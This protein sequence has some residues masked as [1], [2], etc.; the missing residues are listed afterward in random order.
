MSTR[1][2]PGG[3]CDRAE[4][5]RIKRAHERM[6]Q[7]ARRLAQESGLNSRQLQ[8][9]SRLALDLAEQGQAINE[10]ERIT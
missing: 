1:R 10:M 7:V 6:V 8:L 9:L 2:K 3:Y 4:L 5:A